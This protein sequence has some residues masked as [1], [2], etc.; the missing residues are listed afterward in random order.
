MPVDPVD[1]LRTLGNSF[2]ELVPPVTMNDLRGRP[3]RAGRGRVAVRVFATAAAVVTFVAV[4]A[5][6]LS[7]S[8]DDV[9]PADSAPITSVIADDEI[10][11]A[12]A[13]WKA[14]GPSSYNLS[15]ATTSPIG[16][17]TIQCEFHVDGST[18][19][20]IRG[21]IRTAANDAPSQIPDLSYCDDKSTVEDLLEM[22]SR[23]R[24][25]GH[26]VPTTF[27]DDGV[28]IKFTLDADLA[29]VDGSKWVEV[30]VSEPLVLPT[31]TLTADD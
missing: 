25:E 21:P 1:Q 24:S 10:A 15:V 19:H 16:L 9:V 6:V 11:G 29:A 28:P 3:S 12:L 13:A 4:G 5:I 17:I 8:D 2:D 31:V 20:L 22:I 27:D 14:S 23:H 18:G 30:T 7:R 26:D